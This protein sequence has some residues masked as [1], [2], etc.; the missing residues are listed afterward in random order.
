MLIIIFVSGIDLINSIFL[1]YSIL[2]LSIIIFLLA[3]IILTFPSKNSLSES[4]KYLDSSAKIMI[5][6]VD[7]ILTLPL[8]IT[9]FLFSLY[10]IVLLSK[11]NHFSQRLFENHLKKKLLKLYK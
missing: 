11:K 6:S 5:E 7:V 2:L 4:L 3:S 10:S 1:L 9:K 8:A